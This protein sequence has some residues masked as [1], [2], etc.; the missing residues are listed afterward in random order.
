MRR[1]PP[2]PADT[3]L[4]LQ[5]LPARLRA[6]IALHDQLVVRVERRRQVRDQRLA[7]TRAAVTHVAARMQAAVVEARA[8]DDEIHRLMQG[9]IAD[10]LAHACIWAGG[11]LSGAETLRLRH[12]DVGHLEEILTARRGEARRVL[13]VGN[14]ATGD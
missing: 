3:A 4:G 7:D 5:G 13:V 14:G 6:A 1:P 2:P 9:L 11:R 8:L 10:E 12:N